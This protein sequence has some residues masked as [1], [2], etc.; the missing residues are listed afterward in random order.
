MKEAEELLP[1]QNEREP[2]VQKSDSASI[3]RHVS[4]AAT[5][6]DERSPKASPPSVPFFHIHNT[7]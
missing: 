5:A 4:D 7:V 1:R 2:G 6:L 3:H